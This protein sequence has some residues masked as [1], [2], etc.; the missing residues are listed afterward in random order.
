MLATD[1]AM[2]QGVTYTSSVPVDSNGIA[3]H[4]PGVTSGTKYFRVLVKTSEGEGIDTKI[5]PGRISFVP[6]SA[7]SMKWTS[8]SCHSSLSSTSTHSR[9]A[10]HDYTV[11]LCAGDFFYNDGT[12]TSQSNIRY[13]MRRKLSL[14]TWDKLYSRAKLSYVPSDHDAALDDSTAGDHPTA[15]ASFNA[16][17]RD[18]FP[19]DV[20]SHGVYHAFDE[21][22]IRF[23]NLDTRSFKS[24]KKTTVSESSKTVLGSTQEAWLKDQLET[25]PSGMIAVINVEATW[26]GSYVS[27]EDDW[28]GYP[29][30]RARVGAIMEN[31]A[32]GRYLLWHGDSHM[33]AYDNGSHNPVGTAPV[34]CTAPAQK[35]SSIK[36]RS[37]SYSGG[38]YP[39]SS[40]LS[41]RQYGR[42]IATKSDGQIS[43]QMKGYSS[44]GSLVF[45][46]SPEVFKV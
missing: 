22:F 19:V 11:N 38:V 45:T 39:T 32:A 37:S 1:E 15:W 13:R 9:M 20:P 30:S 28:R 17:Y 35:S 3:K 31:A 26:I 24:T 34:Y 4:R 41:V 29:T 42:W 27:G 36:P 23:I 46:S 6:R 25:L 5:K 2:T 40:G 14:S 8:W 7:T 44:G 16:A 18:L 33:L 21:G 10:R 12:G 43:V